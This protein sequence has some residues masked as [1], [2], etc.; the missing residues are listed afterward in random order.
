MYTMQIFQDSDGTSAP[1]LEVRRWDYFQGDADDANLRLIHHRCPSCASE[2]FKWTQ[3]R[4][5]RIG[6]TL[7][8]YAGGTLRHAIYAP[9]YVD[10]AHTG[11]G[12]YQGNFEWNDLNPKRYS[13]PAFQ[14]DNFTVGPVYRR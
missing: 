13:E 2:D 12:I 7:L 11:V 14:M 9:D 3:I 10:S 4:V 6:G 1:T 8:I 5:E